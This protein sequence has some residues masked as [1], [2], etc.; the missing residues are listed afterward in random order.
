M[1]SEDAYSEHQTPLL[2]NFHY[3]N[4][5]WSWHFYFGI[6]GCEQ[7]I[8]PSEHTYRKYGTINLL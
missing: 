8:L 1:F 3:E 6:T 5:F 7:N 2:F 4:V